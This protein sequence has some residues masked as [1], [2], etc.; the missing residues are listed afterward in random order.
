MDLEQ[1]LNTDP[2]EV[3]AQETIHFLKLW[4]PTPPLRILEVGCGNGHVAAGLTALS[5]IVTALDNSPAAVKEA[6]AR[7]VTAIQ[8]DFLQFR[9]GPYDVVLFTRS[10]HHLRNLGAAVGRTDDVLKHGGLIIA[11]EFAR[12]APDAATAGWFYDIDA[13][14]ESAALSYE[15]E[16]RHARAPAKETPLKRWVR[17]HAHEP[18]LHEGKAMLAAL[19]ARFEVLHMQGAPYLYRPLSARLKPSP[20]SGRIAARLLG[21]EK[22]AIA[23][24][25]LRPVGLRVVLR[26][27]MTIA[28]PKQSSK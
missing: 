7:G 17:E 14:L 21:L 12:E 8:C 16:H 9:G 6:A 25:R 19:R 20:M 13:L 15:Q 23:Q 27:G 3:A 18:P 28:P 2:A 22:E 1:P 26:K 11:E 5:N 4:L 24:G 10:L